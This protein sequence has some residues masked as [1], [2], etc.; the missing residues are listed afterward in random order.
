MEE[1][2]A[3]LVTGATGAQ[4]GAVVDALLA[5]GRPVRA[6]VRDPESDAALALAQR[7]VRLHRGRFDD[8]DSLRAA[9]AGAE[10]VFS[11]QMPPH[12]KDPDQE[13]RAAEHLVNAAVEAGVRTLVHTSVARADEHETFVGWDENRWWPP[14][15]TGKAAAN[16]L[17]RSSSLPHWVILK[18]AFMMD[19]FA[20]PK[21]AAMFP[22]L[23]D[24]EITTAMDADVRLDLIAA[25][26]IGRVAAAVFADPARFDRSEIPLA[27]EALTMAEV[28]AVLSETTG[29]TVRASH[30]SPADAVSAGTHSGVVQNQEW[31]TVEGYRV[32]PA[33]AARW[34]FELQTFAEWAAE[35]RSRLVVG[36]P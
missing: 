10:A 15:W 1:S 31:L 4:G 8:R 35:H 13:R 17:V 28:A 24:G 36:K 21:V 19:N 23:G 20:P 12:P 27:G 22:R 34:G 29:R 11:M 26:D 18:P 33:I 25:S 32:D 2:G 6:L 30:L 7:G 16:D 14:Y 3:V 5:A 9:V